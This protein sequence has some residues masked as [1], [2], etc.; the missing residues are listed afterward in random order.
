MMKNIRECLCTTIL[1]LA[2]CGPAVQGQVPDPH[3]NPP[4]QPHPPL[5]A[6]KTIIKAPGETPTTPEAESES[7]TPDTRPL[8]GAELF[9]LGQMG[10]RRN[11][12]STSFDFFQVA[13]TNTGITSTQSSVEARSTLIGHVA[14]RRIWSRYEFKTEYRG[15]GIIYEPHSELDTAVHDFAVEQRIAGRRWNF[16][17]TDRLAYLPESSFGFNGFGSTQSNLVTALDPVFQANQSILT[18]ST[19]RLSNT[20]L[21]QMDYTLGRK[22]SITASGS[23]LLL[24]G[25]NS[26]FVDNSNA[27][28]F[29]GYNYSPNARNT[30][31][32][33]Y[34][35]SL[36]DFG[37]Q[38]PQIYDHMLRVGY[39]YRLTDK[40]TLQL[41]A[42]PE[43]YT[44]TNAVTPTPGQR[45]SWGLFSAL[46]YDLR[47]STNLGIT[48]ATY[49]SGGAGVLLGA[50]T[51][52][53]HL[54]V[55]QRLSR[56]W[57]SSLD[58]GFAHNT[59]LRETTRPATNLAPFN[60]LYGMVTARRAVGRY[61]R[62][63]FSYSIQRQTSD[64]NLCTATV[65]GSIPVRQVFGL[66]F[67]WHHQR[68]PLG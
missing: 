15:G 34:G 54:I 39:G 7:M 56:I 67:N 30:L 16:L 10:K 41:E 65:C 22:S 25:Q 28:F 8:S 3:S 64:T 51:D 27:V 4:I 53:V 60:T 23:Y 59:P 13:D 52:D 42:G 58:A 68:I 21:G 18:A 36:F 45:Y 17:L 6:G 62:L 48:Y 24:H 46:F 66:G 35:F 40:L 33:S 14:L 37:N 38:S 20:V 11:F 32:L 55:E 44:F 50:K 31:A 49:L 26:G 29:V 9:T 19:S 1:G 12:L 2:L 5:P 47:K 57:S 61:M 43:I 63:F